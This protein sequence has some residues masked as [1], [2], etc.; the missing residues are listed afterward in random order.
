M[1]EFTLNI[2]FFRRRSLSMITVAVQ[3]SAHRI[4]C[5]QYLKWN[6]ENMHLRQN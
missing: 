1:C 5:R 6:W 2:S 3:M 4:Q